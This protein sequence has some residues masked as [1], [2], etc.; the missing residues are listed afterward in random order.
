MATKTLTEAEFLAELERIR[1]SHPSQPEPEPTDPNWLDRLFGIFSDDPT[2]DEAVRLGK[3]WREAR[4]PKGY[5]VPS[6]EE[7]DS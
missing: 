2:F 7:T 3:E 5:E 1:R 4:S 6:Q